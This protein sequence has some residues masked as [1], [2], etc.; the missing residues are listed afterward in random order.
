MESSQGHEPAAKTA[1]P[2][3]LFAHAVVMFILA[4][5]LNLAQWIAW[6]CAVLQLFWMVFARERNAA[7][8][9]FGQGLGNW[10]ASTARF[11]TGAS[12]RRPFPWSMWE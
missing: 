5:L 12:D 10:M 6:V 7:L 4:V 11:L 9:D 3:S 8:A 1:L 2:P